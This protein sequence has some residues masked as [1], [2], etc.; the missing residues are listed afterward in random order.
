MIEINVTATVVKA[1]LVMQVPDVATFTSTPNVKATLAAGIAAGLDGV[2][3][4]MVGIISIR[5]VRRL[6]VGRR[7]SAVTVD[8]KIVIPVTPAN[9]FLASAITSDQI[10]NAAS[11]M[12]TGINNALPEGMAIASV[13]PANTVIQKNVQV[14]LSAPARTYTPTSTRIVAIVPSDSH[15]SVAHVHAMVAACLLALRY[16]SY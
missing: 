12:R 2:D 16:L 7:L 10:A 8:Y 15:S 6:G 14:T 13:T 4:T 1:S 5:L 9:T 11:D 3:S